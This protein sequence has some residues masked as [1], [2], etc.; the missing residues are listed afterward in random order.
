[1]TINSM[2][3]MKTNPIL[4]TVF[5]ICLTMVFG[6]NQKRK[7][8]DTSGNITP[9][10]AKMITIYGSENCDHCIDFRRKVDSLGVKYTFK[11]AEANEDYYR[12]MVLKVQQ[13]DSNSD[14]SFPVVEINDEILVQPEL[15]AFLKELSR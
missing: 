11:D 6:C 4:I 5:C 12:E 1:M 7:S 3:R 10:V 2:S 9:K 8:I 15:D 13:K 14:I